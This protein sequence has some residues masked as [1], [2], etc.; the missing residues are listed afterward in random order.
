MN[1]FAFRST[2]R[3][4]IIVLM[5]LLF[6]LLPV[7]ST[8]ISGPGRL[9][10]VPDV[11][12][13]P[14]VDAAKHDVLLVDNDNDGVAD[15]G[16]TIRYTI[17]GGCGPSFP[18]D[19]P[20]GCFANFGD[21]DATN[22][23][24]I[25]TIDANTTLVASSLRTTPIA[26]NDTYAAIGNVGITVPAG[27]GVLVNDNDPDGTT[28][29][30]TIVTAPTTSAN[31][32][33]VALV[34]D[35]S[36]TY[37]PAPGFEGTDTFSYTVQ[38]SDGNQ[39]P[40][41]VSIFVNDVIWF[42]DNS[43]GGGG[44]GRLATPFNSL[45]DYNTT[46]ADDPG[47]VIFLHETGS[48]NYSGG[49][50]LQASQIL[51]GQGAT[52]SLATIAGITPPA[53]IS[54]GLPTT[55]GGTRPV[56]TNSGGSGITLGSNNLLRGL[57]VGDTSTGSGAGVSGISVGDLEI[58]EMSLT[59]L[60]KAL[61][62][63][64]GGTLN[65]LLNSVA[66]TS[67]TNG[68]ASLQNVGGTTIIGALNITNSNS[69][70]FLTN[71]AG[72]LNI[73][74]GPN[75]IN[76][77]GGTAINIAN[78]T[79]GSLGV[80]FQSVSA[81]GADT[82]ITLNN[83]GT[84]SFLVTGDGTPGSG[85]TLQN[86]NDHG[87]ELINVQH[88]NIS[89]MNLINAS[90]TQE[91]G[92]NTATCT[93]LAN[94]T[95]TGCNAPV[96]M[97]N[98]S[99]IGLT[100]LTINGS[101]QH[102]VNGNNVNGLSIS[103]TDVSNIGDQNKENGMHFIN[104]LGTVSL[105]NVS[106]VG[107][108]TRNVL[109]ENNTGTSNVTVTNSTFNT[110]G[111]E[112]G[113][114]FLGLG[115]ANITFSVTD[116]S[117]TDNNAPQIKA[118]AEDNSVIDATITGNDFDGNPAVTGN[119]GVDLAAVD[120]GTLTFDVIG[121][122]ANPQ[123][124]QPFRSHAINVF[125]SGGGSAS[126]KVNGNTITGSAF[127]AGV[128][129]VAQVTDFN[130]FNPSI[131]IEIDGNNIDQIEG[132][133]LAGIHI[134]A[135]DGTNGLT[136]TAAIDATVT[137]NTVRTTDNVFPPVGGADAAIQVYLSDLNPASTPQ[138]RVC[139]NA[140]GNATEAN[141]GAFGE[142]DFFFGNDAISGANSG[143]AQMQGFA[144]SVSNTWFNVNLNTTTT[145]PT[146]LALGLGPI[147]GGTCAPVVS[148]N[149]HV[150]ESPA[151]L[152]E[153]QVADSTPFSSAGRAGTTVRTLASSA[154]RAF[155]S[156]D[157]TAGF[158]SLRASVGE[159][160]ADLVA[161]FGVQIAHASSG[162]I[163][164]PLGDLNPGQAVIITF[165][166]TVNPTIPPNVT[167]VCNQG[168]ITGDNF[169]DVL[170]DDPD[171][172]TNPPPFFADPTC[173]PVPQADLRIEK[174]DSADPVNPSNSFIYTLAVTNDGPSTAQ[175]VAVTD[176]LPAGV[177]YSSDDCGLSGTPG[178]TVTWTIGTMANGATAVCN[179]TVTAPGST[180]TVT[181]NATVAG[182]THDPDSA[183]NTVNETT[184]VVETVDLIVTKTESIDPVVAGSGTGN[185]T[186]VVTVTNDSPFN[187]TGVTLSEVL[188]LPAGVTV[189][190]V[191]PSQGSFSDPAWTV[192]S[193]TV[194]QSETL[195]VVLS[196]AANAAAGTDVVSNTA[197]VTAVDQGL[198]NTGD[199]AAT[200][201]TTISRQ[202]DLAVSKTESTDP[203]FA[204][205]GVGNLTYFVTV[206]NNGP[207]DASGV[208]LSEVLTLP[209]GVTV[210]SVTSSQ[211]GFADPTWTIPTL[212]VGQS[213]TLTV[214]LT[215][216]G[217][218]TA[219]TDV[220]DDTATVTGANE[221][222]INTGDDSAFEATSIVTNQPPVANNDSYSINEDT[223]LVEATVGPLGDGVLANDTDVDSD[224]LTAV[225]DT[226][227]TNGVLVLNSDGSFT[228]TPTAD[229]CG[230]DSFTY[231][232]NDGTVDSNI[233]NVDI[234]VVCVNDAPVANNDSNSTNEDTALVDA[235]VGPLGDGV[236][237]NDTDVENNP[238]TAVLDTGPSNGTL[239]LGSDGA[240]TYT[241]DADYCG[242]DSF[243]YH[244]NDGALDSNIATVDIDVACVND[245]P[246]VVADLADV[247]VDEGET[248]ANTGT[249][250]DVDGDTVSLTTLVGTVTNDG[251]GTWSW[252]FDTQDGPAESQK[253][254]I[255]AD[256]G[257][258]G[259]S[260]TT[261]ALDV[262]NV[263]P[264]VGP[265]LAPAAPVSIN[266]QP[267][268]FT[269]VFTDPGVL[270]THTATIQWGDGSTEPGTVHETDGS[271][272]VSGS[273]SYATTGVFAI[274]V[275]VTDKDDGLGSS[276]FQYVVIYDPSS[277]FVTG[278][279][280]IDSPAGAY[281]P[282]PTLTGRATFG[283]VS[284]YKKNSSV[285]TGNAVFQFNAGD[286]KFQSD[287]YDWL[288][289]AGAK[290]MFKGTGTING[291]G[292][293]G[294]MLTTID[295]DINNNDG[296]EED[297]FRI[298]FWDKDNG[299]SII[300]DNQVACSDGADDAD[301]CTEIGGGSIVIH[302]GGKGS[303]KQ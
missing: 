296:F 153:S 208:T 266:D 115:T 43:A 187:A 155:S 15:P 250:S 165:D 31:G 44:D 112:V 249:V 182:T 81:S 149:Q 206:V 199:D 222:L 51:V 174:T 4:A 232:A 80:N 60:G 209:T 140:T 204:G 241:P 14:I 169:G 180:G 114:D 147:G 70:G 271:G 9:L 203:V 64:G 89:D 142:T 234:D 124:F 74:G 300:Y 301:P 244:A 163:T 100:N 237:A 193:L 192:G 82:G 136:G 111:S 75:S 216:G 77:T 213:E 129:V 92:P 6:L 295:A 201:S 148:A 84:H 28:P 85:G 78:T 143:V 186:Y 257:N 90:T 130:G 83:T 58:V 184:D 30:L 34:G 274:T 5:L 13:N 11:G 269:A 40:A 303:A 45:A 146:P 284:K 157:L 220:I 214:V 268:L 177:N 61:D 280:W 183:D 247:T 102:G 91:V 10:R 120:T 254:T 251:D 123:T 158:D 135:R 25:D 156:I 292:N 32:G 117:F 39:D 46:A 278:G 16:D 176:T 137:N 294:F 23:D 107:S 288:V 255:T 72:T 103:N 63:N 98:A 194:G 290:A 49:I 94:G 150:V 188:T 65:V 298:R 293:Y 101:V 273:H 118:L 217:T 230:A 68:G 264:T 36:F 87:I 128:H 33:D 29:T 265:I 238:L 198:I 131:T 258:G 179:I 50:T 233:A 210:D 256:D 267:I 19:P 126:G 275:T 2:V 133:G 272:S 59:G 286:L 289:I 297:R 231:H 42:I 162:T 260:Q 189:D 106:V 200:V 175:G 24:F 219:G 178:P 159:L 270:D 113:L 291:S 21:M 73:I 262:N 207:S 93:N 48:G 52:P 104:L 161:G 245:A 17:G 181:N 228:Y 172:P 167:Q 110:A 144:T 252:T 138:N 226:P 229:Y 205:S 56:I 47:D 88:V 151:G 55:T 119:S 277:G 282:D 62:I 259:S 302:K 152:S 67:S 160:A 109:I 240:F 22:V 166:V 53:Q 145:S 170:T 195:T 38:D 41:T 191:T 12:A 1:R 171:N 99:N 79:I 235:T 173:T 215:V 95:N 276:V 37:D 185:L 86:L 122:V 121:T 116:S 27:S 225:L 263:E 242:A 299:D 35:G 190:S 20:E 154:V 221:T 108:D 218:A 18:P 285:P 76:T 127:G 223:A 132:V 125:A 248:A 69:T 26:R 243:T 246:I 283:F 253:V 279:G 281:I 197:T 212:T 66:V 164:L 239:V 236:L 54:N 3:V 141:G 287:S 139:L 211:G 7:A 261:F 202:V 224:P 105:S 168:L 71:N 196:V 227:T 134:E 96:Y 97:V 8:S 57:N